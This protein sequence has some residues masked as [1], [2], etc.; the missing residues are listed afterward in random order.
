MCCVSVFQ[1]QEPNLYGVCLQLLSS[2][3]VASS[4]VMAP[5]GF[6]TE[7]S[8]CF[9]LNTFTSLTSSSSSCLPF[10]LQPPHFSLP[11]SAYFCFGWEF[12]NI[13]YLHAKYGTS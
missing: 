9:Q 2:F 1:Y 7:P 12:V 4:A 6:L 13:F 11:K 3:G 5:L 10:G 8:L